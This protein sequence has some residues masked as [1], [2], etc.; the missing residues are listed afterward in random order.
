MY[1]IYLRKSRADLEA[2]MHG[3]GETLKRHQDILLS[4]AKK[5]NISI[6]KI[7]SEIVSGETIS[8]R[9]EMQKLLNDVENGMWE[10]VLVVEVERLA[11]GDTIDQGLVSQAFKLSG[12]KII[13]PVKTFDPNN[14]FDEEYFEFGLFMSRREYKTINRR[15]QNGRIQSTAE[16][17]YVGN[18]A[19]YGYSREKI[20]G[21]KGYKLIINPQEAEAV[22]II[23]DLYVN[24]KIGTQLIAKELDKLHIPPRKTQYWSE[25]TV[26]DIL[27]NPVYIGKIRWGS[28]AVQKK[29]IN[30]SIGKSRP[31]SSNYQLTKGLHDA[32]I[33]EELFNQAQTIKHSKAISTA[34]SKRPIVNPLASIIVCEKCGR[35]MVMKMHKKT[36]PSLMC[37]NPNCDNVSAPVDEVEKKLINSLNLWLEKY[38]LDLKETPAID[39]T[40]QKE[41]SLSE[42][43]N[44]KNKIYLQQ[45][46]LHDLLEQGVYSIDTFLERSKSLS[47]R[48]KI[49]DDKVSELEREIELERKR[50]QNNIIPKLDS[51]FKVYSTCNDVKLKNDL[52]KEVLTKV[53]Y[54]KTNRLAVDS[55]ELTLYPKIY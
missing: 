29:C 19:P 10:G 11:R 46:K 38:K 48:L 47:E 49:I 36:R 25:K 34:N 2:E 9:P 33:T 28:R 13:T 16:G 27:D 52:L 20:I 43:M 37:Q 39:L 32:I 5:M 18:V 14:E 35:K 15:L 17:K 6:T 23:F 3:E 42:Y 41:K 4:L 26:R 12:T 1:C 53:S 31:R 55:F 30:G 40:A 50:K 44:E 8:S 54:N 45:S 51:L 7:Y 21:D 24:K 22:K